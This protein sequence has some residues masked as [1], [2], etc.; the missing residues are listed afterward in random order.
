MKRLIILMIAFAVYS[1]TNA[2][3]LNYMLS[4]QTPKVEI[5]DGKKVTIVETK[6]QR[7]SV[8][9]GV[10]YVP[11]LMTFLGS[12]FFIDD[13]ETITF[14]ID[15]STAPIT[16]P[17]MLN[18]TNDVLLVKLADKITPISNVNF[19]L[20]GHDFIMVNGKYYEQLYSGKV[21]LLK[22]YVR[23]LVPVLIN[24]SIAGSGYGSSNQKYDGEISNKEIYYLVFHG[25]KMKEVKMTPKSVINVLTKENKGHFVNGDFA[26]MNENDAYLK[27]LEKVSIIDEKKLVKILS[28]ADSPIVP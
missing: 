9:T 18:L 5:Q 1:T 8:S 19:T 3:S 22:K 2:Q 24:N 13:F 15:S 27:A 10:D 20:D 26:R 17:V 21:K 7:G 23:D 14:T 12:P 4:A 16:A 6:T 11:R 28:N 25:D